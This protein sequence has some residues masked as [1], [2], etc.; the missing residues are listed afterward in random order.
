M[1]D[2]TW[3]THLASGE[4][5]AATIAHDDA[6][7]VGPST[8]TGSGTPPITESSDGLAT[9]GSLSSATDSSTDLT[10]S[11][12]AE[13]KQAE[14]ADRPHAQTTTPITPET[15]P[16]PGPTPG[17]VIRELFTQ[18]RRSVAVQT[19]LPDNVGAL[20][21]F[22]IISTWFQDVLTV[23]PCLVFTGPPHEAMLLLRVLND[24]CC[25]PVLLPEFSKAGLRAISGFQTLLISEPNLNNRTAPCWAT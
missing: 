4:D 14:N 5:L 24:F 6:D 2:S 15:P 20:V 19:H 21:T 12:N 22:W 9:P 1:P 23:L 13:S 18:I 3:N 10:F 7:R 16:L 8:P 11:D 17:V 25:H